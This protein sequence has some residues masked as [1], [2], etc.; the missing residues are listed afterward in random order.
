MRK[1]DRVKQRFVEDGLEIALNYIY[2]A[3]INIDKTFPHH[4]CLNIKLSII[5]KMK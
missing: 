1:I 2:I 4:I 5:F 3:L